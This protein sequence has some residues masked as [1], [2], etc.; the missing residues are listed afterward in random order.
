[1]IHCMVSCSFLGSKYVVT[2]IMTRLRWVWLRTLFKLILLNGAVFAY[3]D[4]E[5]GSSL[6]SVQKPQAGGEGG[7]LSSRAS[8]Y[9]NYLRLLSV[10]EW[11]FSLF[12]KCHLSLRAMVYI[13][14]KQ[15]TP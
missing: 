7:S 1:M 10:L 14:I 6:G 5:E 15:R 12:L 2:D 11:K 3:E 13:A 4:A 8:L 9:A